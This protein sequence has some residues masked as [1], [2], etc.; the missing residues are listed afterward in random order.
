MDEFIIELIDILFMFVS[1]NEIFAQKHPKFPSADQF[2][3]NTNIVG[4]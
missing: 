1:F 4:H 2:N 3:I